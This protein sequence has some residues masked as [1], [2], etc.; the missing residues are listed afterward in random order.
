M[1]CP[2]VI[3]RGLCMWVCFGG[4]HSSWKWGDPR[5]LRPRMGNASINSLGSLHR[6]GLPGIANSVFHS[7]S[8]V[9]NA[10]TEALLQA[11]ECH[12]CSPQQSL[13]V[14]LFSRVDGSHL[15]RDLAWGSTNN[16]ICT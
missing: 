14:V 1:L 8:F 2:K 13:A 7:P 12:A 11:L 9:Q 5:I 4:G 3:F 6:G 15:P 10:C 16:P